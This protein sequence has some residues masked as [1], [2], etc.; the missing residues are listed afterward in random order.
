MPRL[1]SPKI[2]LRDW[3][4]VNHVD[5]VIKGI[6]DILMDSSDL[7]CIVKG[8]EGCVVGYEFTSFASS[9]ITVS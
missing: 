3:T 1:C 7:S 2:S 9:I 4:A 6:K 8:V 5:Q